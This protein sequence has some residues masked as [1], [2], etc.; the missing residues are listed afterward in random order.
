ME[1]SLV[2]VSDYPVEMPNWHRVWFTEGIGY[3]PDDGFPSAGSGLGISSENHK[4]IVSPPPL[5]IHLLLLSTIFSGIFTIIPHCS[6]DIKLIK[7]G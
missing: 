1:E 7:S 2:G 3:R 4:T 5:H 6:S